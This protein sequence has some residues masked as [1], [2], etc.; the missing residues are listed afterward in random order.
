M[1]AERGGGDGWRI[2]VCAW[3]V[4]GCVVGG[5]LIL[6]VTLWGVRLWGGSSVVSCTGLSGFALE[7]AALTAHGAMLFFHA[8]V[9][10]VLV[11]L[12]YRCAWCTSVVWGWGCRVV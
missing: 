3:G 11:G 5:G 1:G 4:H 12:A 9:A 6:A 10:R 2:G 7:V 8:C